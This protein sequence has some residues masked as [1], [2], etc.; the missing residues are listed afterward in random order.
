MATIQSW[1]EYSLQKLLG[2]DDANNLSA[3]MLTHGL[4]MGQAML[5]SW[6]LERLKQF[7]TT[8]SSFSTAN[9]TASY[10]IGTGQTWDTS[11]PIEIEHAYIRVAG[12]D[13]PVTP[14]RRRDYLHISDKAKAE[15][16]TK[17][18]LERGA[19]N[20]TVFL[21]PVP[22][23][24]ETIW[25]DMRKAIATFTALGDTVTLPLGY[26]RAFI[27]NLMLELAPDYGVQVSEDDKK[28]AAASLAVIMD[29]NTPAEM[30]GLKPN[31]PQDRGMAIDLD[32]G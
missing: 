9:G 5:D 18:Y 2:E 4:E 8:L 10:S 30:S 19:T 12:Q 13:Y 6:S 26:R 14:V 31:T 29:I 17:I 32:R 23:A 16:P 25:L 20:G 1:I 28:I 3:S 24:V 21:W 11:Q 15:R 22:T 7:T 27:W